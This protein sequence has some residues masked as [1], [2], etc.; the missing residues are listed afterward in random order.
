MRAVVFDRFGPP[1]VLRLINIPAPP[2]GPG[3]VR[4]SVRTAGVQPFDTLVRRGGIDVP[5][6]FP[7][8]LGNEFAGT[9]DTVGPDVAGWTPGAEVIGYSWMNA[10]AGYVVVDTGSLVA[11]PP[12]MPWDAAGALFASGTTALTA[13][14]TLQVTAGDT[15]LVHGAAGGAGTM[16]VQL[17]RSLGARVVGTA[18]AANLDHVAALGAIPVRY[19]EDLPTRVRAAAP[20]GVTAVLHAA[21]GERALRDSLS[22]GTHPDRIGTLTDVDSATRLGLRIIHAQRSRANLESLVRA[23]REGRLR[24]VVRARYPLTRI[25]D[26]HGDVERGHGRGKVIITVSDADRDG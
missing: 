12:G 2:A 6:R 14:R 26:A 23:N 11:R 7:Q 18:S 3:Q 24:V 10:Q 22:L 19:G 8:Q 13:L 25:G 9:V 4:V 16:A 17:A 15:L 20:G 21:G 5:V 1:D